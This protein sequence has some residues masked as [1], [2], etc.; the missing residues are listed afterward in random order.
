MSKFTDKL[1]TDK[2]ENDNTAKL[3]LLI[4]AVSILVTIGV[5]Y[6]FYQSAKSKDAV[7]FNNEVN[8][9]QASLENKISLYIALLKGGRGFIE[10]TDML[11]RE[12]FANYVESL[13]LGVN[14]AGVQ[15]IGYN[16]IVSPNE[17]EVLITQMKAEGYTD[18]KLFPEIE[19]NSYQAIIYLEPFD[20]R[21]KKAIGYDMST[22]ENRREAL[23][24]ARDT[25]Q[26]AVSAK[27]F[28]VQ[29]DEN[30][31][32]FGFLIYLPIY[33]RGKSSPTLEEKRQNLIGYIYSSFR[34][35]DF[36]NEIQ[37]NASTSEVAIRIYDGEIAPE[38]LMAQT[39]QQ[40][41]TNFTGQIEKKY[42]TT[43]NSE[44]AG[45][46]WTIEYY[47][48]P[49]FAAQSSVGWTPLIFLSGIIFSFFMSGM[50]YWEASARAKMQTTAAELFESEKQKQGLLEKEQ[51]ARQTAEQANKTKDEFIAVVSHE[52]R[53]PLN[54]IAGWAR[55]LRTE[56]LSDN[57]K[58]LALE[59]IDKNLR[60][61]TQLVEE[62]LDYSQV[63]SEGINL[64]GKRVVFSEVFESSCQQVEEQ[65]REKS[66]EFIKD[67]R[68]NGH[69]IL[70]DKNKIKI[71]I[72][73]LLS[74]AVK[75][76]DVGGKVEALVQADN[77]NIQMIVKDNGKG[78]SADF[79]PHIFD[80]FRQDDA[81][82]T[83]IYGG[84][85]LGLAISNHIVKL[86]NGTIEVSSEGNGKG[87]TFV[88]KLPCN[89]R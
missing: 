64:D 23:N 83:R 80:R 47:S 77:E 5:T 35:G 68:L 62:L 48:L 74:N 15:G 46:K 38:N 20:E 58:T 1:F 28:L 59:K 32:Q 42:S 81:T 22:E 84:L 72:G 33:E 71:V 49:E 55:I 70:G 30:D 26:A 3:P 25:G 21:N 88:V 7:R 14:Y 31:K 78:I 63:I 86:H 10:S 53:T 66:I 4:L 36:L 27:V 6:N 24:R 56:S 76:T 17:R 45:R 73:N 37:T 87:A 75:F 85:G 8:R 82:S 13:E 52:L 19:R 67:N 41:D 2:L 89:N 54:A 57:T 44:V 65:V 43:Y 16:K 39:T 18:F 29:E 69:T 9:T 12:T 61:Q 60:L 50:T 51:K 34:A 79:L 11:N 40:K